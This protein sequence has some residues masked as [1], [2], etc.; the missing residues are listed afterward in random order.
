MRKKHG[1]SNSKKVFILKIKTFL[2]L[3]FSCE[4]MTD[5]CTATEYSSS[6]VNSLRW[7]G[8]DEMPVGAE[9]FCRLLNIYCWTEESEIEFYRVMVGLEIK[10]NASPGD[11][12]PKSECRAEGVCVCV[13]IF[14]HTHTNVRAHINAHRETMKKKTMVSHGALWLL[15]G[16]STVRGATMLF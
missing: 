7:T 5:P 12:Q 8:F 10:H 3:S 16:P 9:F 13:H 2:N 4:F 14:A 6:F 15:P 1:G 11:L